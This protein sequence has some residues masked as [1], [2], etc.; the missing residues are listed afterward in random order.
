MAMFASR[1]IIITKCTGSIEDVRSICL[2]GVQVAVEREG[3]MILA[4]DKYDCSL[5]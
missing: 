1:P 4:I 3:W 2:T 5:F